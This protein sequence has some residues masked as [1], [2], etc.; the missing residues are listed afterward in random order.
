MLLVQ[1]FVKYVAESVV[2][3]PQLERDT[4]QQPDGPEFLQVKERLRRTA[5]LDTGGQEV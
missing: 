4:V 1:T 5:V 3:P 2:I